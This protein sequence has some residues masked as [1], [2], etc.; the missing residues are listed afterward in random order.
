MNVISPLKRSGLA[1][2][3]FVIVYAPAFATAAWLHHQHLWCASAAKQH[4]PSDLIIVPVIIVVS[5]A[6]AALLTILS[7][8]GKKGIVEFGI[9]KSRLS[10]VVAAL[11][12]GILVGGAVAFFAAR[13]PAPS[14]L[15][16]SKLPLAL[17]IAY[18]IFAAP[19]QEELIFR[20]LLQT[21]IARFT[22]ASGNFWAAHYPVVFVA[23]LFGVVHL[24]SGAVVAIGDLL[25]GLIAGELRRMSGSLLPAILVHSLFNAMSLWSTW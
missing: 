13:Y 22:P 8:R 10:Y 15:D 14:P 16:L 18:F 23:L 3:L 25:L 11:V 1:L 9:A 24:G 5:A 7:A 20:G 19:V 6:L 12:S 2:L 21:M 17:T 4:C